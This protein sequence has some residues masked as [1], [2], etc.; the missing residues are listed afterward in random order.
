MDLI[1]LGIVTGLLLVFGFLTWQSWRARRAIVKWPGTIVCGLLTVAVGGLLGMSLYGYSKLNQVHAN[2]IADVKVASD[3]QT[4]ARGEK[5]ARAC[6]GCH[7]PN[8]QLPLTGQ[9]FL[10]GGGPPVGTLWAPNLTPA[11]LGTWSDGEIIRAIREGVNKDGHSLMI[12]P[13]A[14]FHKLSDDD[15]HAIVAYLRTQPTDSQDTPARNINVVG[16]LLVA[17]A[18]DGLLSAQSPIQGVVTAP[19]AGP[20]REYGDYLAHASG[21]ADCHGGNFQ[22]GTPSDNGP[23]AGPSLLAFAKENNEAAFFKVLRT[24]IKPDGTAVSEDMPWSDFEK[25]SDDDL[26]AIYLYLNYLAQ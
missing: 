12:M 15:V 6:A 5:F 18:G 1:G 24:G 16:S 8:G 4:L 9:D 11:H 7:S 23:P 20:T 2:P 19:P 10:A 22:G 21:C 26:R 17:I 14:T 3:A 25:Y 13:S